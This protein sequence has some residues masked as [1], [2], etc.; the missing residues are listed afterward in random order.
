MKD[1]NALFGMVDRCTVEAMAMLWRT[2]DPWKIGIVVAGVLLLV[3]M[4]WVPVSR[5]GA[6]E[7]VLEAATKASVMIQATPTE[8][9]TVTALSKEKLAQEVQQ[10][11]EQNAPD[12]FGWLRTNAALLLSTLV[13]VIGGLIGFF[14][15][16]GDRRDERD[17]RAEERFQSAVT[18]LG[19]EK[20]G[21]RIGAAILLRT[22]L[23]PG[24]EQFYIQTFDLAVAN[25]R[26]PR[27]SQS[28]E[29]SDAPLPL[30]TL[31]QALIMVFKEAFPLARDQGERGPQSLDAADVLLDHAHLRRA[32]LKQVELPRAFL[33]KVDL[34]GADLSE[35]NLYKVNLCEASLTGANLRK[36]YFVRANLRKTWF[37][38]A[39]LCEAN[40]SG[41]D[42]TE[43]NLGEADLNNVHLEDALCL[44]DTNLRGV[45]GLTK[46]Q[47]A[48]CK[49]KGAIIDE[50]PMPGAS[51]PSPR[52]QSTNEQT[53][54]AQ[55][56]LPSPYTDGS[57]AADPKQDSKP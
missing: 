49:T 48:I 50:P 46:E 4:T 34:K 14:R 44:K 30:T 37:K 13:I 32:D 8:D 16:L 7:G 9:A 56:S 20:E 55:G 17:K 22:F 25:L 26:L 28:P 18:G 42:L 33:R 1:V 3:L 36:A 19:E 21:A 24:Y 31:S 6:H 45:L 52:S 15:W 27:T 11:K 57:G 35:A 53:S 47:L 2:S 23:R 29:E 12:L 54:S 43:A 5:A 38:Q 41:A 40:L 10:L 51:S 39:N